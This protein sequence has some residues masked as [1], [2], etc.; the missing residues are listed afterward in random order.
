MPKVFHQT[1]GLQVR[2]ISILIGLELNIRNP[3]SRHRKTHDRPYQCGLCPKKFALRTDLQRHGAQ[4]ENASARFH[5]TWPGCTHQGSV[6]KDNL[7]K[8]MNRKHLKG[9][10]SGVNGKEQEIRK[11]ELLR[12]YKRATGNDKVLTAQRMRKLTLLEA[13]ISGDVPT[14]QRLLENWGNMHTTDVPEASPLSEAMLRAA[15]DGNMSMV[16]LLIAKGAPV[17]I[18]DQQGDTPLLLA[19]GKGHEIVVKC[20]LEKG[21]KVNSRDRSDETPLHIAAGKGH[22]IVVKY[23]LEG[24]AEVNSKDSWGGTSLHIAALNGHEMVVK[25]LLEGGAEVNSKDRSDQTPLHIAV[26]NERDTIVKSLIE[27]GAAVDSEVSHG[28]VG[29]IL[30]SN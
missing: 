8:H 22:V 15:K 2:L 3:Y 28:R 23:L 11:K 25:Y 21:A 14:V 17:D 24:G 19:A 5:C 27:H 26:L 16:S 10:G 9:G 29:P 4:H 6:R 20:L 18:K 1:E 13:V 30:K 12:L 7:L